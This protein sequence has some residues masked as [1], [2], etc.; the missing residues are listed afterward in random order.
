MNGGDGNDYLDGGA[1][2][3][4]MDGGAGTFDSVNYYNAQGPITASFAT[5]SA[6]GDG[7]D[8]FTN[9][10]LVTGGPYADTLYGG[11]GNDWLSGNGGNDTIIGGNGDEFLFGNDGNDTISGGDGMDFLV[12][13]SGIDALDGGGGLDRAAYWDASGPITVSLVDG[14]ATGDG[15]DTLSTIEGVHGSPYDDTIT[16]NDADNFE[17]FGNDGNDTIYGR[18]GND[19]LNGGNGDDTLYGE[20]GYDYLD[21]GPGTNTVDGGPDGD[22]CING[23]TINNCEAP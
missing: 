19:L 4:A 3:D 12:P 15:T 2:N 16:G 17:L 21:G 7:N 10:E 1:G 13:G 14:T 11:G 18:A 5:D 22:Y 23:P 9:V 8:S 20:A 6:S